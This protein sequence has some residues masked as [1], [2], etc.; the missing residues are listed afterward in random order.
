[1]KDF[2]DKAK[3]IWDVADL[4]R[5]DYRQSGYGNVIGFIT[6]LYGDFAEKRRY[7]NE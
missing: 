4:L 2:K 6:R 3:L 7:C 1:M 5:G